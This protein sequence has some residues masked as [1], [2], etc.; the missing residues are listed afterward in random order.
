MWETPAADTWD[1]PSEPMWGGGSIST[2]L[3]GGKTGK[4]SKGSAKSGKSGGGVV[5]GI[6]QASAAEDDGGWSTG[7][8][9]SHATDWATGWGGGGASSRLAGST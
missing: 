1:A 5:K 9:W 6:V 3:R 8:E 4:G 2:S 7:S